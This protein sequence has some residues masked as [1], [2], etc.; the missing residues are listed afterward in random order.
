MEVWRPL[1]LRLSPWMVLAFS[2]TL[3]A[4][5]KPQPLSKSQDQVTLIR[6]QLSCS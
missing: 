4:A 5:T 1:G 6:H 3:H 2:P